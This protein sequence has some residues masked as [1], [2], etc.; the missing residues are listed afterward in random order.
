MR[1]ED[2]GNCSSHVPR[3]PLTPSHLLTGTTISQ[4]MVSPRCP[5]G[6]TNRI[7]GGGGRATR[8]HDSRRLAATS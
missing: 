5:D 7:G 3:V 8:G 2:R 1:A 6:E 4:S